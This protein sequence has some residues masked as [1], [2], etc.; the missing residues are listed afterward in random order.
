MEKA[1]SDA[2]TSVHNGFTPVT[3][4]R[5]FPRENLRFGKEEGANEYG[6]FAAPAEAECSW[7]LLT[8][9]ECS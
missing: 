2:G 1:S 8:W 6:A 9:S 5:R 7:L 4:N 3:P